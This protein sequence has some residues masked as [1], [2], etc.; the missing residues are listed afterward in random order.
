[1]ATARRVDFEPFAQ[2]A[3]AVDCRARKNAGR[4]ISDRLQSMLYLNDCFI[5]L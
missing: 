4:S 3:R 1:M 2:N 5:C